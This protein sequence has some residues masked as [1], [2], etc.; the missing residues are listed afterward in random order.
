MLFVAFMFTLLWIPNASFSAKV[1]FYWFTYVQR[2]MGCRGHEVLNIL[3]C[4]NFAG[5]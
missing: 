2:I 1:K 3:W 4:E 5:L